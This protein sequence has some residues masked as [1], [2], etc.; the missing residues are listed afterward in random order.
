MPHGDLAH[1]AQPQPDT[2]G[3]FGMAGQSVEG[4]EDAL[5]LLGRHTRP[6]VGHGH[7]QL[8]MRAL[9]EQLDL[10]ASIAA[11]ILKQVAQGPAQQPLVALVRREREGR[12][13]V[14]LGTH[15]SGLFGG[16][17][18]EVHGGVLDVAARIQAAGQ[19]HLL[20]QRVEFADVLVDLLADA[21]GLLR[22][23]LGHQRHRHLQSGQR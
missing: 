2:T 13:D 8:A 5:A 19:Q 3:V 1:Q 4:L 23:G 12:V 21:C 16:Q 11:C 17:A 22:R 9:Q 18:H 7:L 15:A 14:H 20:D 10:R 6:A